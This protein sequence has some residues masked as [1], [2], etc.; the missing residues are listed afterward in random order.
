[1]PFYSSMP[2]A[3]R[4]SLHRNMLRANSF[5]PCFRLQPVPA[6]TT[7]ALQ[8]AAKIMFYR[9]TP[10]AR[11]PDTGAR[12]GNEL[13]DLISIANKHPT[14]TNLLFLLP[15]TSSQWTICGTI[16]SRWVS[17]FIDL[18]LAAVP[19]ARWFHGVPLHLSMQ[20][21]SL[22]ESPATYTASVKCLLNVS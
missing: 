13:S 5:R 19:L 8:G 16:Y 18:S 3:P 1:M 14:K 7:W 4:L 6:N 11:T 2:T 10:R 9:S 20:T 17:N 12:G 21:M 15:W 22:V